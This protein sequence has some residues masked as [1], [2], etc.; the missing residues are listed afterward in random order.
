MSAEVISL[1]ARRL[2]PSL[3]GTSPV[4]RAL[5]AT[6]HRVAGAAVPVLLR[7]E[8][9]TG[10]ELVARAIHAASPR[11]TGR[12]VAINCAAMPEQLVESELFGHVRGAFTGATGD[13]NGVFCEASGGTLMLDEIGDMPL[14]TQAKLLRVLQEREVRP[15]GGTSVHTVDVRVI[16]ATHQDL[17]ARVASG[18]FRADLYYRLAVVP[19]VVPALRDRGDDIALLANHFLARARIACPDSPVEYFSDGALELLA[20]HAWPGNVR[21]LE[22]LV[23]RLVVLGTCAEV[24]AEDVRAVIPA[25]PASS[26]LRTLREVEDDYIEWVLGQCGANKVRAAEILG[27]NPSTLY[28]RRR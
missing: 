3:V 8:S 17:E 19:L 24:S 21:E 20:A 15:V 1:D 12:F 27:V 9:G 6:I 14:A 10:K 4:M 11:R 22:N 25:A 18:G 28:R 2:R 16:A 23:E 5:D 13:R 26:R 7:G